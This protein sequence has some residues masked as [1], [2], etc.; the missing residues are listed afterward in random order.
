MA[1]QAEILRFLLQG[2]AKSL[3]DAFTEAD[4]ALTGT[5]TAAQRV[6]AQMSAMAKVIENEGRQAG[7]AADALAM[8]MGP[9]LVE[10]VERAGGSV[11]GI[12]A[13]L[14]RAGV[15]YDDLSANADQL[16]SSLREVEAAGRSAASTDLTPNTEHAADSVHRLRGEADQSRSV[17]ANMVGNSA[18]DISALAGVSGTAGVALGQLAEYAA[19]GNIALSNLAMVAAPIAVLATANWAA[20]R[21]AQEAAKSESEMADAIKRVSTA[22]DENVFATFIQGSIEAFG[23]GKNFQEYVTEFAESNLPGLKR[24]LDLGTESGQL[25]ADQQRI[26]AAA[27]AEA[28][29][30]AA[31]GAKTTEDYGNATDAAA[32]AAERL[33]ATHDQNV[34]GARYQAQ[35]QAILTDRLN[36]YIR[37]VGEIPIDKYTAIRAALAEGDLQTAEALLNDLVRTRVAS[38]VIDVAVA[39]AQAGSVG[40]GAAAA[41][42]AAAGQGV[43][44]A[45][46]TAYNA[47]HAKGSSGG[48]GGG[49]TETPEERAEREALA[50]DKA[51]KNLYDTGQASLADYRAYLQRR[52]G[53][54]ATYSDE[55]RTIWNGLH[56]LDRQEL[57][58]KKDLE[59]AEKKRQEEAKKAAEDAQKAAEKQIELLSQ[60]LN[61]ITDFLT[62]A[63]GNLEGTSVGGNVSAPQ[64]GMDLPSIGGALAVALNAYYRSVS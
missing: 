49:A 57:A 54:Y 15:A 55:Y 24:A 52:L 16:A 23:A 25:N 31:Q 22:A 20:A 29:R 34:A 39:G 45:Y 60:L 50:F 8:A 38:V 5:E 64:P 41:A 30:A 59:D 35:A 9:E 2:E 4:A 18:Q 63:Y 56:D 32:S 7:A 3:V 51:Y 11:Q 19:D 28:E 40:G 26:M 1:T 62:A 58:A 36:Q 13:D 33:Y 47:A 10:A 6:A 48:G 42:A 12:V 53:D 44:Q 21:S 46:W 17:L 14:H 37:T 27:I 43:A 61:S